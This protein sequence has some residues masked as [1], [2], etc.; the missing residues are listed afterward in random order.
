MSKNNFTPLANGADPDDIGNNTSNNPTMHDILAAR[1]GRRGF[2]LGSAGAAVFGSMGLT[3]CLGLGGSSGSSAA[4]AA[5]A[6]AETLLGFKPV[7][8]SLADAFIVPEGYTASVIYAKGD[9]LFAGVT[10]FK[11]DGTDTGYDQRAGD[12]HD[13]MQYF[14][15]NAAGKADQTGASRGLLGMNHEY[16]E[17]VTLF[18]AGPTAL[19]RSAAEADIEI[20]CHGVSVVEVAK[21]SNGRF[22]TVQTS[23]FNRRVTAETTIE[24]AGPARGSSLLVTKFSTDGTRT[25]GTVNNCGTGKTPWGT[26]LTGEENWSGYFKR[27]SDAAARSAK[28]IAALTRYGRAAGVNSRYGWETAGTDDRYVRWDITATGASAAADYRNEING[29]GYMTEINPYDRNSVVKKRT[30]TGRF[31]H[32][33]AAFSLLKTGKPL[34]IYMGDDSQFEYIYKYVS[35]A[36]WDPADAKPADPMATGDKYLDKGKLYVAKFNADGTGT[37]LELS[38]ANPLIAGYSTYAFADQ[39]D[40]LVNARLAADA[41]GATKMDRPEWSSTHPTTGDIYFTLTNNSGRVA[42]GSDASKVVNA[43]NPRSYTDVKGGTSTQKGNVNGHILRLAEQGDANATTFKWDVY[44]FGSEA[45]AIASI[46]LSGLTD[47]N[48]FSSP[49][50]LQFAESTGICWI[51]TDDGNY[52]DMTN[53]QMLAALPGRVGDGGKVSVANGSVL[54]DTYVGKKPTSDTLKRFLVG[55]KGCEVTGVAETPDG[56]VMFVNIQHPGEGTAVGDLGDPSKYVS[57]WPSNSGYGAG[58]RPRSAT[59]MITKNDGGRIGT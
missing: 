25:R 31:A 38:M 15:L 41:A 2:M 9:P 58:K 44:L 32:E 49:D 54:V 22:A 50:G 18:P 51:Q 36:V 39:A 6:P 43:A 33:G 59:V 19:P 8:K 34:A 40:I 11:N 1:I 7:A 29:Q 21:G 14:G 16:I 13:G 20:A 56:K 30:S 53:D 5:A 42:S 47:V 55:P 26:L 52:T 45:G 48:D 57:Q 27:G 3:G 37:W 28:E 23:P 12:H 24:L 10:A 17:Q 35:D 4:P 46:N